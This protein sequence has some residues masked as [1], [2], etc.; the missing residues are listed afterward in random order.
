MHVCKQ[1]G[2]PDIRAGGI[3]GD[4]GTQE[5]DVMVGGW[6]YHSTRT[7]THTQSRSKNSHTETQSKGDGK[8]E[9]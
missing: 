9:V 6:G 8:V 2:A 5:G 1:V 7:H 4:V 3:G